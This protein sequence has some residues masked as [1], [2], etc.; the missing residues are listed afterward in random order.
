MTDAATFLYDVLLK[1]QHKYESSA[2]SSQSKAMTV[3]SPL[4]VLIAA[5]KSDLFTS[6]PPHLVRSGLES[7]LGKIRG[8]RAKGLLQVQMNDDDNDDQYKEWLGPLPVNSQ[9]DATNDFAFDQVGEAGIDVQVVAGNVI[10]GKGRAGSIDDW[11]SWI[12]QQL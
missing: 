2:G 6:L 4:G 9:A 12:G 11:S 8:S 10:D 5:N 3:G 1:L 7:E